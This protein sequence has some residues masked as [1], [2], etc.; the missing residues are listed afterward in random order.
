MQ[1]VGEKTVIKEN[2]KRVGEGSSKYVRYVNPKNSR[3]Y[4]RL[5]WNKY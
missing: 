2:L 5:I 3:F 4:I 1:L